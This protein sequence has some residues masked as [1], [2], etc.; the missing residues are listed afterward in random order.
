VNPSFRR[1]TLLA[2]ALLC[3]SSLCAPSVYAQGFP[4]KPVRMVVPFPPGGSSDA[5]GRILGERLGEEWKQP[6]VIDN[7]PG[8]GTTIA[9]TFVANSAPDGYT[10]YLQGI[11]TH[12]SAGALYKNTS[13]DPIKAFTPVGNVTM[14]PFVLVVNP[15][16]KANSAKELVDLARSKPE[17]L[18]YASSGAGGSPHL[19]SEMLARATGSKFLHVPYKGMAPAIVALVAG[20]VNFLVSDVAVMPQVRAGKARALAVTSPRQSVLVPGVPTMAESGIPGLAMV[21]YIAVL[22]PAGMPRDIVATLNTQINRALANNDVR[23]KLLAQGFEPFGTTPEE[24]G[25]LLATETQRLGQVIRD[26]GIKLD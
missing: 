1:L 12:A 25:N 17:G 6:L 11:S 20:E 5:V 22:G 26:I 7:K 18:A 23:Q 3:A 14:S 21:A 8:A 2:A 10:L 9:S 13:F 16:I 19:Y 24:V 4:A 15:A